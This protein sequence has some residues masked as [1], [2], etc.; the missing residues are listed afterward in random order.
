MRQAKENAFAEFN[1]QMKDSVCITWS[2]VK[3]LS[4]ELCKAAY[5]F[6]QPTIIGNT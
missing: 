3:S 2:G 6:L 4:R 5:I 1:Q